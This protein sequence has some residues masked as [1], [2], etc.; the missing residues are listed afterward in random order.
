MGLV[1]EFQR[2]IS[3]SSQQVDYMDQS[4][5]ET[6]LK[7]VGPATI[8]E[9]LCDF[10]SDGKVDGNQDGKGD[11]GSMT[12]FQLHE[13]LLQFSNVEDDGNGYNRIKD[14]PKTSKLIESILV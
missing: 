6:M 8:F 2:L 5:A 14:G 7:Y 9:F 10:N 12:G 11:R 4:N 3:A 13:T 1:D